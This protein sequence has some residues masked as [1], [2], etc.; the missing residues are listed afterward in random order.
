V[1]LAGPAWPTLPTVE[2]ATFDFGLAFRLLGSVVSAFNR[3]EATPGNPQATA[4][5]P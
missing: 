2:E 4:R 5:K 1:H 3:S